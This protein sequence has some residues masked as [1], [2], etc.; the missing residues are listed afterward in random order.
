MPRTYRQNRRSRRAQ[1]GFALMLVLLLLGT[2]LATLL[3][4][5]VKSSAQQGSTRNQITIAALAQAKAALIAFVVLQRLDITCPPTCPAAR[6]GD[7][8]CPD[9][10]NDGTADGPCNNGT[11][12]RLPWNTLGLPADLRDGD[13]E[14]LWYAFSTNF[15]NN[16][17]NPPCASPSNHPGCLN[18]DTNGTITVRDTSGAIINNGVPP[19]TN[20]VIAVII[21]PGA[22][23]QRQGAAALQDRSAA[24]VNNAVN[25][26]DLSP[27]GEDNANFVD[28]TGNGFIN[29]PILDAN[30]NIVVNDRVLTITYENLMPL[31]ERRV[32]RE[33]FNCLTSYAANNNG[34]YPWAADVLASALTLNYSDVTNLRYGRIP[35]NFANTVASSGIPPMMNGW[36]AG[37]N[38][39]I[40]SWWINWEDLVFFAEA[41]AFKPA[42]GMPP[43]CGIGNCLTVNGTPNKQIVVV[44]AGRSLGGQLRGTVAQ[45]GNPSNY[46]EGDDD[47]TAGPPNTADG[48]IQRRPAIQQPATATSNDYLLFFP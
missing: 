26:L 8:P 32:A 3:F 48:F 17:V 38:I 39:T 22:A 33:V 27:S 44:V 23:L 4:S 24:G 41:D 28:S 16:P 37:C 25:Y 12:G 29:G 46:L 18:S 31:M 40:G 20:G 43:P 19:S 1:N 30:N 13:G 45:K 36:T 10:N 47:W 35:N 15:N 7:L 9:I 21:A 6:V 11:I 14:R 2:A 34:H 5:Y 42:P